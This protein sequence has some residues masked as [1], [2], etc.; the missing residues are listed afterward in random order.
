VDGPGLTR[1][2]VFLAFL[3]IA[4]PYLTPQG[5]LG[6]NVYE[7]QDDAQPG[8]DVDHREESLP[9]VVAGARSPKPTVVNVVT[10]K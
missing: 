4:P 1:G 10:L 8:E 3:T 7:P 6:H 2:S 9:S 5:L